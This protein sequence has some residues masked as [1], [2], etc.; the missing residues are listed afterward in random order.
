VRVLSPALTAAA[1][2]LA[3]QPDYR[4]ELADARPHFSTVRDGAAGGPCAAVI[5]PDGSLIVAY[6]TGALIAYPNGA[7]YVARITALATAAQWS[8]W[9]LVEA[10]GREDAGVAL[11]VSGSTVRLLWQAATTTNVRYA[12]SANSGVGWSAAATLFNPAHALTG[13]TGEGDLTILFAAYDPVGLGNRRVAAWRQAAG[14]APA[15]WTNGDLNAISGLGAT[16]QGGGSFLLAVAAQGVSGAAYAVSTC[17]YAPGPSWGALATVQTVDLSLGLWLSYAKLVQWGGRYRL[18]YQVRDTGSSSGITYERVARASSADGVQW[19]AGLQDAETFPSGAAWVQHAAGQ[20]LASAEAARFAPV[21][22]PAT[23]YRDCTADLTDLVLVEA[24]GKPAQLTAVL[25][26]STG[27]YTS[28]V[29][30]R[31]NCQVLLS[32]GYAG[33][34]LLPTHLLYIRQWWFTRSVDENSLTIVAEDAAVFLARKSP[35]PLG[36]ANQT[37]LAIAE[38]LAARGGLEQTPSSDASSQF[39]Q[40]V[41]AFTLKAGETYLQA[42]ERLLAIYA[43]AWRMRLVAGSGIAFAAVEQLDLQTK[44]PAQATSWSYASEPEDLVVH[45]MVDRA[46]HLVAYGPQKTATAIAEAWDFGDVAGAGE[47]RYGDFVEQELASAGQAGLA[48]A[49]ALAAEQRLATAVD[50]TVMP[51]PGLELL[52][53]ISI[54][55]PV[56]PTAVCRI[57]Q[58]HLELRPGSGVAQLAIACEGL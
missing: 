33:A 11:I 53:A 17:S 58:L 14:W 37:V 41:A 23:M 34:G 10:D 52:D 24:E 56:L 55:D 8:A 2:S 3:S 22:S 43:G 9:S 49:N 46:N 39:S 44:N 25:D 38:D 45:T 15:D 32:Q 48:V 5:A 29:I 21:Y 13:L 50:L 40:S 20:V 12:D 28:L 35:W 7:V 54:A 31:A 30:L 4:L 6:V 57:V 36:Y 26:N 42:L 27:A 16:N 1:G 18:T 47:E 19:T 51:H